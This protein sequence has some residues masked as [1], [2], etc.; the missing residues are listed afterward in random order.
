[1]AR[2]SPSVFTII[3]PGILVAATG[4]GAGDLLTATL[5]GSE[6][7]LAVLWAV[8]AGAILK[9]TLNEGLARWQ[10]ATDSTLLEG[11]VWNLGSWIQWVF[12]AYLILFTLPVGG[13]LASACGVAG[14]AFIPL[15]DDPDRTKIIWGVI[16]SFAGYALVRYGSFRLFELLMSACIGVMFVTVVLT[17][18]LMGPDWAAIARGFIPSVPATGSA[19][20]LGVMG[21]VGGTVTMMSYGYWI[22]EQGRRGRE[23]VRI[24]RIDLSV[25]YVMTALFGMA[26]IIIG[27]RIDVSNQGATLAIEMADELARVV[28]DW[29]RTAFLLGFWGAVFSSLLGV[30]QSLP[31]L[32]AD[33][34]GLRSGMKPGLHQEQDLRKTKGYRVYL[35]FISTVPLVF[36]LTPVRSLQLAFGVV[37]GGFLGLLA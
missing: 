7:G 13:A 21:G 31:Y 10:L 30:W 23:N 17:V 37:A 8:L 35:A 14:S 33:F 6:V 36:L 2:R 3:A 26:V 24:C 18:L 4:V 32:F 5:A 27:S 19:W 22:R 1:M 29:G 15:S 28:G 16:H 11:W 12:L 34:M 25:G 9:W 20:L